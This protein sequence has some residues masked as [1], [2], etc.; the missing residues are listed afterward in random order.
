MQNACVRIREAGY[1]LTSLLFKNILKVSEKEECG[2]GGGEGW[3]GSV[4]WVASDPSPGPRLLSRRLLGFRQGSRE[5]KR[6]PTST[7]RPP[8]DCRLFLL[9]TN[10]PSSGCLE[11]VPWAFLTR[12]ETESWSAGQPRSHLKEGGVQKTW[13]PRPGPAHFT[14]SAGCRELDTSEWVGF[15]Q[16]ATGTAVQLASG[17]GRPRAFILLLSLP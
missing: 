5:K 9:R 16:P 14:G 11:A 1:P 4:H 10:P 17:L 7:P 12:R 8:L 13:R 3:V 6:G 15:R 2:A